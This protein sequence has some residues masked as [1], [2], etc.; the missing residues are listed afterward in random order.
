MVVLA[1]DFFFQC[2]ILTLSFV[3]L[4]EKAGSREAGAVSESNWLKKMAVGVLG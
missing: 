3:N 2:A 4:T 1:T